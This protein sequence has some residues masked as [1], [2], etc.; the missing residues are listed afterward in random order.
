MNNALILKE[1]TE[2]FATLIDTI[3]AFDRESFNRVDREEKWTAGQVV[4]HLLLANTGFAAVLN[5]K[6]KATERNIDELIPRLKADFLNFD[7]KMQAP[8]F[9]VPERKVYDQAAQLNKTK[10]IKEMVAKEITTLDLSKTCLAFELPVYGFLT[11]LEAVYFV[12][13]HTQR[14]TQQLKNIM[15]NSKLS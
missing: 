12:I 3:A 11:R 13:Y 10:E 15:E 14:H 1:F 6:V 4:E 9:I 7:L 2:T 5:A 8:D